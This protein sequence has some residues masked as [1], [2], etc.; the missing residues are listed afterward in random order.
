MTTPRTKLALQFFCIHLCI[1]AF[2]VGVAVLFTYLLLYPGA[3]F[4][5]LK[6]G[7]ILAVLIAADVICG[8]VITAI[9]ASPKKSIKE[10]RVDFALVGLVQ[11][12]ALCY[13]MYTVW[14][15]RPVVL[16]F[17][18]DRFVL[19][20]AN[21]VR[22]GADA[23]HRWHIPLAGKILKVATTDAATNAELLESIELAAQGITPA[24]RTARWRPLFAQDARL[25]EAARPVS[26]LL[27]DAKN[28][29]A[30]DAMVRRHGL[31]VESS[32]YLPLTTSQ[33]YDWVAVM[34]HSHR[35][36]DYLHIDAFAIPRPSSPTPSN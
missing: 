31:E 35:V 17:E 5:I 33:T 9:L 3:Y 10:R 21:E 13:G 26:E 23:Q 11:A 4:Y 30:I 14:L 36:I 16:A 22:I 2:I 24:M 1:S 19:V 15:S 8:P 34:D 18:K 28:K 25:I 7:P 29:E 6:V 20:R 32:F 12:L 27:F